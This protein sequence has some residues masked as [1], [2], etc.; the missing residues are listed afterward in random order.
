MFK[1]IKGTSQYSKFQLKKA[2]KPEVKFE[3]KT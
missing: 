3:T 2:Y 1:N